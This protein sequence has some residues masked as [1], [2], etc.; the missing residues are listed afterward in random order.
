MG[1][2]QSTLHWLSKVAQRMKTGKHNVTLGH[3][4][5]SSPLIPLANAAEGDYCLLKT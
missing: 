1:I 5:N 3:S 2:G 4:G